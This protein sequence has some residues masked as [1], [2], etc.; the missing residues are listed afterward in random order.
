[1]LRRGS[2]SFVTKGQQA[3]SKESHQ[4]KVGLNVGLLS[5][6]KRSKIHIKIEDVQPESFFSNVTT[7]ETSSCA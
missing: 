1:M 5:E 6:A 2:V 4:G 7:S 3:D